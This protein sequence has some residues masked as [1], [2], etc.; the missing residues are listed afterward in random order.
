[1]KLLKIEVY[2]PTYEF[3]IGPEK[4]IYK[5]IKSL[6]SLFMWVVVMG[7]QQCASYGS[8]VDK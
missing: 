6:K 7:I 1:M 5:L 8:I 2:Y 4:C 3:K